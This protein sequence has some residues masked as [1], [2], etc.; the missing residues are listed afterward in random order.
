MWCSE[1]RN[2]V[3][4]KWFVEKEY[5]NGV[6]KLLEKLGGGRGGGDRNSF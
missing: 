2:D 3:G 4:N 1:E 6:V 5:K